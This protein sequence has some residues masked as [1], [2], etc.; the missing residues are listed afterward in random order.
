MALIAKVS[1]GA[2]MTEKM[3]E[4]VDMV[5]VTESRTLIVCEEPAAIPGTVKANVEL[6]TVAP[7]GRAAQAPPST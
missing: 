5:V 6:V 1:T 2:A 4:V 7:P 3:L